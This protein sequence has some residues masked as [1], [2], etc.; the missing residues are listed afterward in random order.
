MSSSPVGADPATPKIPPVVVDAMSS[1]PETPHGGDIEQIV[2]RGIDI[3]RTKGA[4]PV[5][6]NLLTVVNSEH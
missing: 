6:H 4:L 5:R 3:T 1:M 2:G